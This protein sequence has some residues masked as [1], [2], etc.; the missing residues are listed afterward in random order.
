MSETVSVQPKYHPL[1]ALLDSHLPIRL[2]LP[3]NHLTVRFIITTSSRTNFQ[4]AGK[5]DIVM[6]NVQARRRTQTADIDLDVEDEDQYYVTKP[7]SSARRYSPPPQD[8]ALDDDF[9][10][11]GVVIQRRRS[12][13]TP[14]PG[15]SSV[16]PR[17]ITSELDSGRRVRRFPVMALLFG[18]VVMALLVVS[19]SAFG[20]WWKIHQDDA[21]YGRPR[22]YQVDAIVGHNDG[23]GHPSHFIFMNLNRHVVIIELPGGDSTKARI[24]S[25]P[26]LFGDGQDLTPVTGEFRDVNGDGR[27]DMIV[28]ILDQQ[29]VFLNDGKEFVPQPIGGK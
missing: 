14:V 6:A 9:L 25:G 27:P 5:E 23:P 2:K 18:M 15:G 20:S 26:T 10:P 29:I 8:D 19:I 12:L 28:H 24:Y 22:T 17:T 13:A 4:N 11:E 7:R 1:L 3:K 16:A 21:T